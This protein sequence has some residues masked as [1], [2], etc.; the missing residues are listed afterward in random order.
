M[1]HNIDEKIKELKDDKYKIQEQIYLIEHRIALLNI[2]RETLIKGP[3]ELKC[4][5]K[6]YLDCIHEDD[7]I[8]IDR[9]IHKM[10]NNLSWWIR[11]NKTKRR[12]SVKGRIV[13]M[14]EFKEVIKNRKRD[15][16]II[17]DHFFIND[18]NMMILSFL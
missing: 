14:N 8:Q 16:F 4:V 11:R 7:F 2:E 18:L 13:V 1:I 9:M 6:Q 3:N 17:L 5:L 10:Q 12:K 15:V